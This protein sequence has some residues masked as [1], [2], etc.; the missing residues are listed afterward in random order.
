M[1][2]NKKITKE[3]YEEALNTELKI[4]GTEAVIPAGPVT[5]KGKEIKVPNAAP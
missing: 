3:E 5:K 4:I 2:N 1:L